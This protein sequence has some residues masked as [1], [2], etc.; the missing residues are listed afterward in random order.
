MQTNDL[1]VNSLKVKVIELQLRIKDLEG[2][3]LQ[4]QRVDLE[5][6]HKT[7]MA[8]YEAEQKSLSEP[9]PASDFN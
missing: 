2:V 9:Q 4:Y 7:V 1:T 5:E 6:T 3:I 8:E